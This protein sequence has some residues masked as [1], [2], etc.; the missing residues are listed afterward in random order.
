VGLLQARAVATLGSVPQKL[1]VSLLAGIAIGMLAAPAGADELPVETRVTPAC[2][3]V[4]RELEPRLERALQGPRAAAL[5]ASVIIDDGAAGYHVTITLLDGRKGRGRTAIVAPTCDEALDAAV[6]V[7]ALA[8]GGG[9][10]PEGVEPTS[11]PA[12]PIESE[13]RPAALPAEPSGDS[14]SFAPP[15]APP[16]VELFERAPTAPVDRDAGGEASLVTD[17]ATRVALSTGIDSG[18]LP[19]GTMTVSAALARSFSKT[20]LRAVVRYGLPIAD[21]TIESDSM[22][23]RRSDFGAFELRACRGKGRAVRISACAGAE[24]GAVRV[25]SRQHENGADIDEDTLSPRLSGVVAALVSHRGG[26][27]EPEVELGGAAVA[28]GRDTGRSWLVVRIA[29]GAAL[30]F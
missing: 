8:F 12:A 13:S 17:R 30:A 27:I 23:S 1:R 5:S 2:V 11:P 6:V 21:E 14:A 22:A 24:L 25:A 15:L 9:G 20:D 29:A 4:A 3:A 26:L 28:V 7:L 16:G 18:S 10:F 19:H